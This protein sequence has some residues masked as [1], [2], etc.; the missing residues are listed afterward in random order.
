MHE[1]LSGLVTA[2]DHVGI[3]VP[4]LDAAIEFQRRTFG[5]E[6]AH[7]EVNEEQGVHEAMLRAPGDASGATQIQLLAPMRDDSAIAKFIGR[8][9]PGL[10]Q[11]AY[12]VTD[13]EA[14]SEA[15]RAKGFRLL[16]DSPRR[17]TADSRI[18][19]VHPKDAGGV[20]VE[21]VEPAQ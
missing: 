3:A 10:Q 1:D 11:L 9:G 7:I 12:R 13:V 16:Y 18:N 20:L 5:L 19:F 15:L 8:S 4:D 6:V 2:I 17:G 14:A 21:L